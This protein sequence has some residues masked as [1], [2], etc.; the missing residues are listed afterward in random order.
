MKAKASDMAKMLHILC[1][2]ALLCLSFAHTS[3]AVERPIPASEIAAYTLPDGT[4]PILCLPGQGDGEKH[5][6][7]S[8]GNGCEACRIASSVLLPTPADVIG[9]TIAVAADKPLPPLRKTA[10]AQLLRPNASPRAP[11]ADTIFL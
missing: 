3:P 4:I 7:H 8:F 5:H 1:A 11:P 10:F 9:Q 6:T 2:L